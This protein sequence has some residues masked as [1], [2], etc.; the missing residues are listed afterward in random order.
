ML[1]S[2]GRGPTASRATRRGPAEDVAGHRAARASARAL[3][4]LSLRPAVH[5]LA[6]GRGVGSRRGRSS[7][8]SSHP[9]S[10]RTERSSR[11]SGRST[12][13]RPLHR[14]PRSDRDAASP[15]RPPSPSARRGRSRRSAAAPADVGAARHRARLHVDARVQP[16]LKEIGAVDPRGRRRRGCAIFLWSGLHLVPVMAQFADGRADPRSGSASRRCSSTSTSRMIAR[17]RRGHPVAAPRRGGPGQRSGSPR[18]WF[19]ALR[20]RLRPDRAARLEGPRARHARPG[21]HQPE[22]RGSR[23]RSTSP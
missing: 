15:S 20:G 12:G 5:A 7:S 6:R 16:L 3:G 19:R 2:I 18:D 1:T 9:S 10:T 23:G 14:A 13:A 4:R 11:S 22:R 21:R 17:S 8:S